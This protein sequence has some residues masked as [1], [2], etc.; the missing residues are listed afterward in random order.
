MAALSYDDNPNV[1][2]VGVGLMGQYL[3]NHVGA[4]LGAAKLVLVDGGD[5]INVAGERTEPRPTP[6][7]LARASD[8]GR[9]LR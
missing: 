2:I 6:Q 5:A 4:W 8:R 3:A 1:M 9:G 7:R